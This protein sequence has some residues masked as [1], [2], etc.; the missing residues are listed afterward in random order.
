MAADLHDLPRREDD[1]FAD[2]IEALAACDEDALSKAACGGLLDPNEAIEWAVRA[3]RLVLFQRDRSA[4]RSEVP[5]LAER[6]EAVL[7]Q[8]PASVKSETASRSSP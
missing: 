2:T 1:V 8:V 4:L 7:G 5:A 3:K 6:L